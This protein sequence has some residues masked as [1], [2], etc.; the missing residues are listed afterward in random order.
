MILNRPASAWKKALRAAAGV[1]LWLGTGGVTQALVLECPSERARAE[2]DKVGAAML[3]WLTDVV[4]GANGVAVPSGGLQPLCPG[5]PPADLALVP[6]IHAQIL[7]IFLVPD[8]IDAVPMTDPWGHNYDYRLN[9]ADPLS[10]DVIA[11]RSAGADGLFEGTVYDV[12]STAGPAG[13]LVFYYNAWIRD[14]PQLD[15]VSRQR[16]TT[17]RV[18]EVGAALL[19][20]ITDNVSGHSRGAIPGSPAAEGSTIDLADYTPISTAELTDHLTNPLLYTRCVPEADAWG[21][22]Y[23]YRLNDNLLGSHV[24]AIRSLGEDAAAEGDV[25]PI[26]T[27]PADERHRDIVWTDGFMAREPD[28]SGLAIFFDGFESEALWGY[29]SCGPGY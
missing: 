2:I 9:V 3:A 26:T 7:S 13:D 16:V 24:A 4:S 17:E 27:F 5:S 23:D 28:E 19:S 10:A 11:V 6:P 14:L 25:Y 22:P 20:W 12:R 21:T 15:A 18:R 8:Y 1:V 29:W